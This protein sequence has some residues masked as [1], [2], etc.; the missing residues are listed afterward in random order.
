MAKGSGGS[1]KG[2][3]GK[4]GGANGRSAGGTAVA[5][6][7]ALSNSNNP[8]NTG[9]VATK[10]RGE[11]LREKYS[12][13]AEGVRARFPD[14]PR[15]ANYKSDVSPVEGRTQAGADLRKARQVTD[16][17][18]R[19]KAI[20][21]RE[22][23]DKAINKSLARRARKTGQDVTVNTRISPDNNS[24]KT[25]YKFQ[26]K[27]SSAKGGNEIDRNAARADKAARNKKAEFA[28]AQAKSNRPAKVKT[29]ARKR[30]SSSKIRGMGVT[31]STDNPFNG[32]L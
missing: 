18:R 23:D 3:A 19:A 31:P 16:E 12:S 32:L 6:A 26:L 24:A 11:Q 30:V 2:G 17:F 15:R 7:P 27:G 22:A 13:A 8:S 1:G 21:R 14:D 20:T 25:T 10:S 28:A 29:T 5:T 4:G 9:G